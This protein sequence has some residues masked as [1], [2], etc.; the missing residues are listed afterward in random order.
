M[1]DVFERA[2]A[3]EEELL[4]D[5]LQEQALHDPAHGKTVEDSAEE[6]A[7]CGCTIPEGRRQAVPGVQLCVDCKAD[8]DRV[9]AAARRNGWR[10]TS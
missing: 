8:A 10:P 3:R 7:G 9:D 6:C 2:K 1:T 5:A 4:A